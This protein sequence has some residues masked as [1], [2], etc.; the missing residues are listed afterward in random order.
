[1]TAVLIALAVGKRRSAPTATTSPLPRSMAASPIS[2]GNERSRSAMRLSIGEGAPGAA[3][4]RRAIKATSAIM[5][6]P[7]GLHSTRGG[8]SWEGGT[9]QRSLLAPPGLPGLSVVGQACRGLRGQGFHLDQHE[10][11]RSVA[12]VLGAVRP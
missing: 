12:D 10:G 1:M 6:A 2:P 7:L 11:D 4:D 9:G 3:P 8:G 5:R